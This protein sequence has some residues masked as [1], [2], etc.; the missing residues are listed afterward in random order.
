MQ[1]LLDLSPDAFG[2]QIVERNAGADRPGLVRNVKTEARRE[3]QRAE[4]AEAVFGKR[5]R[6]DD[7]EEAPFEIGAAMKRVHEGTIERIPR[8]RVDR[9]V[10]APRRVLEGHRWIAPH[11]EAFVSTAG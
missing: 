6:I 3:L 8:D 5:A 7:T 4:D 1:Q 2:G 10:A 11:V 9:E